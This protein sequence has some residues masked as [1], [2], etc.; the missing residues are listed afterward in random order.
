MST[1]KVSFYFRNEWV[2]P[3]YASETTD[4]RFTFTLFKC[5][6]GPTIIGLTLLNFTFEW[7][8]S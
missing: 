1:S 8:W 6:K 3:D 2:H 5:W 4:V 7:S